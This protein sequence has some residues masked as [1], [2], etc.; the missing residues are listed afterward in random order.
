MFRGKLEWDFLIGICHHS[1]HLA[2]CLV[3]NF[4]KVAN[5]DTPCKQKQSVCVGGGGADNMHIDVILSV[6]M[7]SYEKYLFSVASGFS[8][9]R[10]HTIKT[11]KFLSLPDLLYLLSSYFKFSKWSLEIYCFCSV[12][13]NLRSSVFNGRPYSDFTVYLGLP[14]STEDLIVIL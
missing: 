4:N 8:L 7:S 13:I 12:F 2:L 3:K 5:N 14:F 9:V 10:N 1:F 6:C 11:L